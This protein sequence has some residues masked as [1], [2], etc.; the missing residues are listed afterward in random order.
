MSN[1][2][3]KATLEKQLQLLVKRSEETESNAEVCTLTHAM[4]ELV[5]LIQSLSDDGLVSYPV[6]VQMSIQDLTDLYQGRHMMQQKRLNG[7]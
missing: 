1:E 7:N 2:Q 6:R 5:P 4:T 3:L